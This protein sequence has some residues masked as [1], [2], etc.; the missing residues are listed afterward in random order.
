MKRCTVGAILAATWL[1]PLAASADPPPGFQNEIVVVGLEQPTSIKFLPDGRMLVGEKQ[2][3]IRVVQPEAG[4]P[5]TQP[6]L[7]LNATGLSGEQGLM[8]IELDPDFDANGHYYVFYTKGSR[9]RNRVSRFTANGNGTDPGS[10]VLLW[11]GGQPALDDH[12][13]GA[14][15]FGPDG[16]L[17]IS[18]GEAFVPDDAQRLDSDRGKILRINPDG[19]IP[20]DNPFHDGSGQP[21]D[22][23][24]ALGLRNPFR[25]SLDGVT[26]RIFICEVGGNDPD[27]AMEEVNLL[28][29]GANY[30]W[31]DCEGACGTPGFTSPMYAYPHAGRD[32]CVIGGC[33]YRG[34]RFPNAYYGSFFFADYAQHWIR[35]LTFDTNGNVSGQPLNFEPADGTLDGPYGDP[36]CLKEGPDGAL[37]Y[38]DY[39]LDPDFSWAM[40]RRIRYLGTNDP[41]SAV[42][43]AFPTAGLPPLTVDF[44]SAGSLDPEGQPVTFLWRFGDNQTSTLPNPSHT[45]QQAGM[46]SVRLAV[47][48]GVNTSLSALLAI[49]VGNPPTVTIQNPTNGLTFR[50][51]DVIHFSGSATDPEDGP[52]PP[53]ALNWTIVF[54]HATHIHP[55]SGPWSGTNQGSLTIPTVGHPYGHD[56]SYEIILIATDSSGLQSSASV[57]VYPD[58]IDLSIDTS[59]TGLTVKLDGISRLAPFT[60]GTLIGFQHAVEAPDQVVSVS[61]FLFQSWS[62]GGAK[63][64]TLVVPPSDLALTA[65]YRVAVQGVPFIQSAQWQGTAFR[66]VFTSEAGRFYRVERSRTLLPGSWA[67]VADQ[68]PGTGLLVEVID[69]AAGSAQQG[70]YRVL[71]LPTVAAGPPGFASSAEA[72]DLRVSALSTSLNS[73]GNDR[74]LVVGLCWDDDYADLTAS[75]TY[76]GVTC[77][78]VFKTNWFYGSGKVAI[79]SLTAPPVGN[80]TL[81]VTLSGRA[82]EL[83]MSGLIVTNANQIGSVGS[84]AGNFSDGPVNNINVTVSSTANDLVV[85]L[86]GYYALEPMPD[87]GQIERVVSDNPGFAST[88]MST[89]SGAAGSTFMSWSLSDITEVSQIA[90]TIKGR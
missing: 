49:V 32:A 24:W 27:I 89:K 17:Y 43:S 87:V 16:K 18:V 80:Q 36:T 11:E 34:N 4:V 6:F 68:V 2:N 62:D 35:R 23:I 3:F 55:V 84:V 77:A 78:P 41:P 64:H 83:S 21:R 59:P 53:S 51:G 90:I 1:V 72:H 28:A 19:S 52:L 13:G 82:S 22:A 54:H 48:D 67:T 5:D 56:T 29:R 7:Q 42:A 79:Y 60:D 33:V 63:S 57:T 85:D 86:L 88:R 39:S 37:Y 46:Y 30:G 14:V 26:G 44:S 75:V 58:L 10:E 70:F 69:T 12:Q 40:I 45:Y 25:C 31:P 50:A 61:N 15:V 65:T 81:Q 47:S 66:L 9:G 76:G 20:T 73:I 74:V 8:D 38:T 71:L